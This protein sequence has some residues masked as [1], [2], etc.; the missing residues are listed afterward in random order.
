MGTTKNHPQ[1]NG[2][3]PGDSAGTRKAVAQ[4]AAARKRRKFIV[5][6][7]EIV[8]LGVMLAILWVVM[9]VG[10][11]G[12]TYVE[13]P[14]E[15]ESL[16]IPTEVQQELE[17]EDSTMKGYWNI[18]LFGLDANKKKQ[19][20]KGAHSDSIIIA[21]INL[22]TE[23]IRLVSVLR[24]TY[25]N[26]NPDGEGDTYFKANNAYFT[27]GG[28]RAIKMLNANLDLNITDFIAVGF[29]GLEAIVDAIG[30]VYLDVDDTEIQHI[31]NYQWSIFYT[32]GVDPDAPGAF[33]KVTQTGYQ[34]LNG[35]QATAYCRIRY[36]KGNDFA[37]TQAQRE[38]LMA[39]AEQAKQASLDQVLNAFN[40]AMENVV[41]SIQPEE[42]LPYV[43]EANLANFKIVGEDSLPQSDM[44][45]DASMDNRK[46][47]CVIPLDLQSNV[48]WLH[49]FLFA[50][51]NYSVSTV[52]Q[53]YSKHIKNDTQNRLK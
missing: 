45:G 22:D 40:V 43:T 29:D 25:L 9:H 47:E 34:K 13:M 32:R 39:I 38:L 49:K 5:F 28:E 52:V 36:R 19:L 35:L 30:G 24:D 4:R 41:T 11:E 23:E 16:A 3:R 33:T 2:G 18:A 6:G 7:V 1:N 31:D 46:G 20:V 10:G 27:G 51:E 50:D 21:S 17:K 14:S 15:P 12:P 37:R 26:T 42:L 53:E 44:W 8:L 48:E